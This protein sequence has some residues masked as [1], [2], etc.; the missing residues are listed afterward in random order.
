M[1]PDIDFN[2]VHHGSIVLLT[3]L[4]PAAHAWAEEFLPDDAQT[5]G[6]GS[7]VVEPRYIADIVDGIRGDGLTVA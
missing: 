7:V 5:W 2:V 3:P 6:P 1:Q 4:T